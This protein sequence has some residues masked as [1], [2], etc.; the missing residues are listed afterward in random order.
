MPIH[1]YIARFNDGLL[2]VASTEHAGTSYGELDSFKKQAKIIL[3]K[4]SHHSEL[5]LSLTSDPYNFHYIIVDQICTMTLTE[6]NYPR[7]LAFKYLREVHNAFVAQMES[8]YGPEYP[9]KISLSARPYEFINFDRQIIGIRKRY[10][11]PKSHGNLSKL[12]E[13]LN[14]VAHV[15][16]QNVMDLLGRGEKLTAVADKSEQLKHASGVFANKAQKLHLAAQLRKY[17]PFL[18]VAFVVI[19]VV[20]WKLFL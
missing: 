11:D 18:A 3:K 17:A 14:S 12:N 13:E 8:D 15:M 5:E 20:Y 6:K 10:L 16:Q 1:T 2:L 7:P 4:L 19:F 9:K